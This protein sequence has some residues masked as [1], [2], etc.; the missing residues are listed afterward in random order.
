MYVGGHWDTSGGRSANTG[1]GGFGYGSGGT[2]GS[3][4]DTTLWSSGAGG[5]G[6]S[7]VVAGTSP[8]AVAAAGGGGGGGGT[9][10]SDDSANPPGPACG[11]LRRPGRPGPHHNPCLFDQGRGPGRRGRWP[12]DTHPA[13]DGQFA[14]SGGGGGGGGGGGLL[15]G[16]GGS[17]GNMGGSTG[18][19]G[20]G[21]TDLVP[22]GGGRVSDGV[23][24]CDGQIV[25]TYTVP[26]TTAP[27]TTASYSNGYTPGHWTNQGVTVTLS[28]SDDTGGSGVAKTYYA[29]DTP[30][31]TSTPSGLATATPSSGLATC[32]VYSAP[33]TISAQGNH[34]LTY[35]S[36]DQA[37]H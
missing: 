2:P 28:A 25:I 21:G 11:S 18:G 24:S 1:T 34:T 37:V 32:T 9:L 20:G 5:G 17:N 4:D 22:A 35:F 15:G 36:T 13:G 10:S 27:S 6:A 12:G 7:A 29:I 16:S 23:H 30:S 31:C 33:F 14:C 8:L 26:D 19:G 3:R